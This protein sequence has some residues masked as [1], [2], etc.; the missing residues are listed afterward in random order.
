MRKALVTLPTKK[1]RAPIG[2]IANGSKM[3]LWSNAMC[4]W[5]R[6]Q[7]MGAIRQPD[8]T[9]RQVD[10][11]FADTRSCVIDHPDICDEKRDWTYVNYVPRFDGSLKEA[12]HFTQGWVARKFTQGF[13]CPGDE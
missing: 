6:R 12:K 9:C 7:L 2:Y 5:R 11:L 1:I 8:V 13:L 10:V 4:N 3:V